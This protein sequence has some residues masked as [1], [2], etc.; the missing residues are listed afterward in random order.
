MRVGVGLWILALGTIGCGPTFQNRVPEV[1]IVPSRMIVL[2]VLVR[3]YELDAN[4]DRTVQGDATDVVRSNIEEAV[5][6]QASLR[7]LRVFS[8]NDLKGQDESVRLLFARLWRWTES[9]SIEIAAQK[10]GHRNFGL[11]SVGDW[12]FRPS[13]AALSEALAADTALT[14]MISDTHLTVGYA[15]WK[16]IGVACLLD[17]HDGRM[18][19]CDALVD[20]WRSLKNPAIAQEAVHELLAGLDAPP[21]PTASTK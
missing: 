12:R 1:A 3:V 15:S 5:R 10:T 4:D 7:R 6:A 8:P 21:P 14:V 19:W 11:H 18:I 16:Q 20:A 9:A 13:P 2:P 17:L